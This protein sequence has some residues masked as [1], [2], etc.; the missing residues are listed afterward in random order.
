MKTL[1]FVYGTLKSDCCN[2]AQLA[3]QR[4]IGPA[5]T[6]PGYRLCDF[7]SYP[8]LIANPAD[9]DGVAGEVWSVD[10]TCLRA[11]DLFEGV[12]EGLYRREAISLRA[13]FASEKIETFI[14]NQSVVGRRDIGSEWIDG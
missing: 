12:P 6:V 10:A 13:P 8:G 14:Y 7:G 2:Q 3:G 1:L 5:R 4:F 11:L 9:C